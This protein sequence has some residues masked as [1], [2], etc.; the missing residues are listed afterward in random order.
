MNDTLDEH[1]IINVAI[2]E[3]PV[4]PAIPINSKWTVLALGVLGAGVAGL[5]AA[6]GADYV[7]PGFRDPNDVLVILNAPVLASLP[8]LGRRKLRA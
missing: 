6:F 3:E 4:A 2:A 8:R 7:D 5:G 1:R